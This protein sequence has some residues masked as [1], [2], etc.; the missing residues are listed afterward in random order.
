MISI[1][2][3]R[4]IANLAMTCALAGG[5]FLLV[6]APASATPA[7]FASSGFGFNAVGLEGLPLG[8]IDDNDPF[9]LAGAPNPMLPISVELLGSEDLCILVGSSNVCQTDAAGVTGDY[10]AL[11]SVEVNVIDATLTGPFTL[12]LNSLMTASPAPAY[13]PADVTIELDGFA[14]MGL[15][16]SAVPAFASRYD[17]DFDSFVHLQYLTTDGLQVL[18][19]YIGWTVQ[20]GDIVTFRY[21]V[22]GG[23][24]GGFTPQLSANATPLVV[25][26]PGVAVLMGLGLGGLALVGER[27]R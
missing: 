6:V 12:F 3:K 7:T 22:V 10:S 8:S 19:N 11:V 13:D 24:I 2:M 23:S 27:R 17:S 21:D 14:P 26:E 18:A 5:L 9:P 15:D 16:T 4:A 20:D 1:W 25:P